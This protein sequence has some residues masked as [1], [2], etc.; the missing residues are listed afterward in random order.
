MDFLHA[1][2]LVVDSSNT[3][4]QALVAVLAEKKAGKVIALDSS[5]IDLT[6]RKAVYDWFQANKPDYVFCFAGPHG[7]IAVN[8]AKPAEFIADNLLIHHNIIHN[9]YLHGV[10][11]LLFM[12]G[13]CVY[14]K[15]APQPMAEVSFMAGKMEP[16]SEAYST[17]SAAGIEMCLA[18]NRQYGT[19]FIPT[20]MANYYGVGDDFS[21]DGHV[22]SAILSKMNRAK[23]NAQETLTLWGTGTPKRQFAFA[24]DIAKAAIFVMERMDKP[25]LI[26]LAVG[27]EYSIAELATKAQQIVGYQGKVSFDTTK[28]DGAMRKLLSSEKLRHLG[29]DVPST[30]LSEG[31]KKTYHSFLQL[32]SLSSSGVA[33]PLKAPAASSNDS[34]TEP[35][36]LPLM[37]NNIT[38]QDTN[39]LIEFL[40][41]SDIFTQNKMVREFE[42]QWSE[43]LGVK[44]S[45]FLNSGSS[46]NFITLSIIRDLYGAG[47]VIVSPIGW[48]SDIG[49]VLAAGHTPVFVDVNLHN[50]AMDEEAIFH[51]I[52][53]QTKAVLLVHVLGFNGLTERIRQALAERNIPLIEDTCESHGAQFQGKKLGSYGLVSNFSFYYAHHLSTIEGG[54]ICTNDDAIYRYA[55]MYRSHG[56]VR[57]CDDEG[58]KEECRQKHPEVYPEFTFWV[59]GYNMRSTELN[60]VIG[61]SQL[62]R[63]DANNKQRQENFKLFLDHLDGTKYFTDFNLEGSVNY[64][65]IILLRQADQ[66]LF[67]RV[68]EALRQAKVEFRRG[69]AGGGNMSRQPFI[70]KACPGLRPEDYPNAE[71]IHEYGIYVGN[72]P[73]LE[74]D[75]I[76]RL[77]HLLNQ[78]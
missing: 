74:R 61:L 59:P 75:K 38:K 14:P 21:E 35:I 55:R 5:Q 1:K 66:A 62:R 60:A 29:W 77:C 72:Y 10:K 6:D 39:S 58:F 19:E 23:E 33:T 67:Q 65:F 50:F 47:E 12:T 71:H 31:L 52:T 25:E 24:E 30:P 2:I 46:A 76:L 49:S 78:Q 11:R 64:A 8:Q 32:A 37:N 28:P 42:R 69:T 68:T 48:I 18:Y 27:E 57:E 7:G 16:T 73:G 15:E 13:S 22:L 44:H 56:M 70:R 4:G 41:T 26:N 34:Q 51:A 9:S 63:L 54:M 36:N 43:W 45:V 53:P 17:A 40:R 20:V 3:I